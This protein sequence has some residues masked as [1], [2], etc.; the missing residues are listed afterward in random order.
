MISFSVSTGDM[1]LPLYG[2]DI[3]HVLKR[4]WKTSVIGFRDRCNANCYY[5]ALRNRRPRAATMA[6]TPKAFIS[7]SWSSPDHQKWVLDLAT[8]LREN[9]VDVTID[10]WDLKEGHDAIAFM[11]KM[12]SDPEVTKVIVVLDRE[13]AEKADGRKGGVGTETQIISPKI[14]AKADQDKFVGVASETGEDGKP[15]LPTFY[16]SRIYIDLSQSD[17]Y[18]ANFEQLLRWIYDKP[19]HPKPP[20]GK[21]PEFLNENAIQLPT[22]SRANRAIDLLKSGAPQA[23]PA[24]EEYFSVFAASLEAFRIPPDS[25]DRQK[26]DDQILQNVETFL[27]YRD[28]FISVISTIARNSSLTDD[29]LLHRLFE[30]LIPYMFRPKSVMQY[31]DWYWDNFAFIVHEL[32]L[33]TIGLLLKQ[34]R[35]DLVSQLM[36]N[37]YYVGD[38][39]DNPNE[40][41]SKFGI[42]RQHLDS[43]KFRNQRLQLNRLSVRADILEKRSHASGLQFVDVMQADF[44]LFLFDAITAYTE[45]GGQRWWPE[46]LVFYREHSPPFEIFA[47]SESLQYFSK[48]VPVLAVKSK[49]ELGEAFKL[50]G[51]QG[52]LRAPTWDMFHSVSLEGATNFEK[53]L[54]KP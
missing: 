28:E 15:F 26:F 49:A 37:G 16:K 40:P 23:I 19:A 41:M 22:R 38:A 9:G 3:S 6:T 52:P 36:S 24:I 45:K 17:I 4:A 18:A 32:F 1:P 21:P 25:F 44:V 54:T 42:I 46:T 51:P 31:N 27:P 13:Y 48:V 10:K 14:Y 29:R 11:E 47:R 8:Q 50:F 34:E 39:L 5:N 43:L 35:F 30:K 7:Y 2:D 53:L 33:Y 12:V 20:L